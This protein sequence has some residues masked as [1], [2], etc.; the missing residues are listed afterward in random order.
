MELGTNDTLQ[1]CHNCTLE[2]ATSSGYKT[3]M[4]PAAGKRGFGDSSSFLC[5]TLS[6]FVLN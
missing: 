6:N 3:S 2:N 1:D 4:E 5:A